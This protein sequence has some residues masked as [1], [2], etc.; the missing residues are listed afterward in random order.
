MTFFIVY[1]MRQSK[2]P[3]SFNDMSYIQN[4]QLLSFQSADLYDLAPLTKLK[5]LNLSANFIHTFEPTDKTD[6][7]L[8]DRRLALATNPNTSSPLSP[9]CG[10]PN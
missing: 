9:A 7:E 3:F 8:D 4:H 2:I 10:S 1:F 6:E 5:S